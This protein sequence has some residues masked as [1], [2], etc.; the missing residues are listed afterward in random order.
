MGGGYIVK[1][2][3]FFL[4]NDPKL[5]IFISSAFFAFIISIINQDNYKY[6]LIL[7]FIYL[8]YCFVFYIYKECFD[9]LY[10][11]IYYIFFSRAHISNLKLNT[12]NAIKILFAWEFIVLTIALIYYHGVKDIPFFYSF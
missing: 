9:L 8:N 10:L 3:Q 2:N 12:S 6:F 4:Y 1:F 7:P 5:L 11:F